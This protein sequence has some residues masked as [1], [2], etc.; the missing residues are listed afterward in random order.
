MAANKTSR[1]N[2]LE[3][4]MALLIRNQA[5]FLDRA[6]QTDREALTLKRELAAI[7][8]ELAA[9]ERESNK[10]FERIESILLEHRVILEA[11]PEAIRQKI[12]FKGRS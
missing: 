2:H 1:N 6:A 5:A 4:A 8:R 10:R 3:E 12:G 9:I 7:E 11:L